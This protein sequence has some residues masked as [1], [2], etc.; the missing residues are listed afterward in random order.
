MCTSFCKTPTGRC[1]V[2]C[3]LVQPTA[4]VLSTSM[5]WHATPTRLHVASCCCVGLSATPT[6]LH[7]ASR[8]FVALKPA[9]P[10]QPHV[11]ICFVSMKSTQ[12]YRA[13]SA[14][15]KLHALR[16]G[17]LLNTAAGHILTCV[18]RT[19]LSVRASRSASNCILCQ[20][21]RLCRHRSLIARWTTCEAHML[22][23]VLPLNQAGL[24][25]AC[26]LGLAL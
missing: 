16:H 12:P 25:Q 24:A 4:A 8:C 3:P 10:T 26:F 13:N 1:D 19:Q 11:A 23:L 14:Y 5:P 22:A 9:T 6:Q 20:E 17:T 2:S 7:V 15:A 18:D 21:L